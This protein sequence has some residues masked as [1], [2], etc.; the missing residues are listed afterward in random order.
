M[1]NPSAD[2]THI[3]AKAAGIADLMSPA[4]PME[5]GC[6][7]KTDGHCRQ[8]AVLIWLGWA[9]ADYYTHDWHK[10]NT[11]GV[12]GIERLQ[13]ALGV[14]VDGDWGKKT[15][16]ALADVVSAEL[17][18]SIDPSATLKPG[19]GGGTTPPSKQKEK[20]KPGVP[21][22]E[23]AETWHIAGIPWWAALGLLLTTAGVSF[24][25]YKRG[26]KAGLS[27]CGCAG[28]SLAEL[29]SGNEEDAIPP[30]LAEAIESVKAIPTFLPERPP[31]KRKGVANHHEE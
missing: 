31:H 24:Y 2:L 28:G 6:K 30:D 12:K 17:N 3:Q 19:G 13:K 1:P 25:L 18:M 16:K 26:K 14:K 29:P 20:Q 10:G 5:P 22:A 11:P 15:N 21:P 7:G 23:D 9:P 8:R 27:G 4:T